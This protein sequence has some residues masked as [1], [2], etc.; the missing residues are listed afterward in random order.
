MQKELYTCY[1]I[2]ESGTLGGQR[3]SQADLR[4]ASLVVR[5]YLLL[6]KASAFA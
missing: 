3:N 2:N 1:L 5:Q 6:P 4:M